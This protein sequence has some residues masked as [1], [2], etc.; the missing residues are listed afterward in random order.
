MATISTALPE[1]RRLDLRPPAP[2][3]TARKVFVAVHGIGDQFR[4]AT[5]QSVVHRVCRHL[6][7]P[8]GIPLGSFHREDAFS[9][10][11][12]YPSDPFGRL[13]FGEVYWA[14]I[15]RERVAE[16][17]T[18]E[19]SKRWART[20]VERL[21]LRWKAKRDDH[22]MS[23]AA[24]RNMAAY[25]ERDF[26]LMDR[27]LSEMIQ[28]IAVLDR[29]SFLAE[30]A[31]LFRFDLRQLLDDYLGDVQI[32]TEFGTDR[33]RIV[34]EFTKELQRVH[35]EYADEAT[36]LELYIVAHSEGTVVAL[37]G[38][39]EAFRAE[40]L[41]DWVKSVRGF[42][43]LGSPIDKHLVLWPELFS[44]TSEPPDP[45][46]H[47]APQRIQ[48]RNYFDF[49]DPV[50]FTLDDARAWI[51]DNGWLDVFAFEQQHDHGFSRYPFPGKAHVD[52]WNDD[53]VFGH[54]MQ[55]VADVPPAA[56]G[57]D[58]SK[59]PGDRQWSRLVSYVLPYVGVVALLVAAAYV[60]YRAVTG[61][62]DLDPK[63]FTGT[64][65]AKGVAG[66]A[67]L[68]LGISAVARIPRLTRSVFWRTVVVLGGIA[69][70]GVYW[71]SVGDVD[72]QRVNGHALPPRT[73][74]VGL[75]VLVVLVTYALSRFR[76]DWGLRPLMI[77]GGGAVAIASALYLNDAPG[78]VWPVVVAA[79]LFLYLWWLAALLFDLVFVW[80]VYIRHANALRQIDAILGGTRPPQTEA[81]AKR[82]RTNVEAPQITK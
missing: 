15:P 36:P 6:G 46:R 74:I 11:K 42:M 47:P 20:I 16:Q 22:T 13:G 27:V 25:S 57:A 81:A 72:G 56:R 37:L 9:L 70:T 18:V 32:V 68:L 8:A 12:P 67:A 41:P 49:G 43:T 19:E 61:A 5:I 59:P 29:I 10:G 44:R 40:E 21:W 76:P 71:W 2:H 51:K 34:A 63:V 60:L 23:A 75:A 17:H 69:A 62:M 48:W 73:L 82:V 38:L 35:G 33:K 77:A 65:V 28:T 55:T 50:G 66:V 53:A 52:Y 30:K 14:G 3:A 7:Y 39:L 78:A 80:H 64:V 24:A 26:R 58:Y 4:Y 79:G 54:F 45:P 31:G 1:R